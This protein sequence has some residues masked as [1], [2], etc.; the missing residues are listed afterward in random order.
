MKYKCILPESVSTTSFYNYLQSIHPANI[1][2]EKIKNW[3]ILLETGLENRE[4]VESI[5]IRLNNYC[6]EIIQLTQKDTK[7]EV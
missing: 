6:Q 5:Q 7:K 1:A 3:V 4:L 2:P